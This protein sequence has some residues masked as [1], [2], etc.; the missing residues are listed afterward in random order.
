MPFVC[1][2]TKRENLVIQLIHDFGGE[3]V[4][5]LSGSVT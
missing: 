3:N 2:L 4:F 5:V 1:M